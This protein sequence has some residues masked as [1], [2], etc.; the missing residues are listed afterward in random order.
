MK[1]LPS[2]VA[3]FGTSGL[4][5]VDPYV[6]DHILPSLDLSS[7]TTTLVTEIFGGECTED[8]IQRLVDSGKKGGCGCVIGLG[9]GKVSVVKISVQAALL[10]PLT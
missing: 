5:I 8:E 9:G 6:H 10:L 3:G 2:I 4:L 1:M 7:D